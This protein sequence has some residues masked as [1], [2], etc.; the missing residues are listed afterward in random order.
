M[1]IA[2][3]H[4]PKVE[5]REGLSACAKGFVDKPYNIRQV[6]EV[7]RKRLTNPEDPADRIN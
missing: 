2:S 3:G 7:V 5:T 4:S 6:L 1:I